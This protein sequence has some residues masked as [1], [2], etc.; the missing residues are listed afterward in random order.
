MTHRARF[1]IPLVTLMAVLCCSLRGSS[2]PAAQ[3]FQ[4]V[5]SSA[6]AAYMKNGTPGVEVVYVGE[7]GGHVV[8]QMLPFGT[9]GWSGSHVTIDASTVFEIGSVTKVFTATLASLGLAKAGISADSPVGPTLEGYAGVTPSSSFQHITF[10]QLATHTSGLPTNGI[11]GHASDE[12][13]ADLPPSPETVTW[14]NSFNAARSPGTCWDYSNSGFVTL[15]F[16]ASQILAPGKTSQYNALLA[17]DVTGPLSMYCTNAQLSKIP[18]PAAKGTIL[19]GD[20]TQRRVRTSAS[21][22]K[23]DGFDM[24]S[25][26]EAQLGLYTRTVP[27][28]PLTTAIAATQKIAVTDVPVCGKNGKRTMALGWDIGWLDPHDHARGRIYEKN[29]ATSLGGMSDA[30]AFSLDRKAGV[31]VLTNAFRQAG[32]D[33]EGAT[34]DEEPA[35][36]NPQALANQLLRTWVE[37]NP[38]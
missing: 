3:R 5:V 18:C 17:N 14:W 27:P 38:S 16:A 26:V 35:A 32:S 13:F 9:A 23:S 34:G 22:L 36:A 20:G 37:L 1:A 4:S 31:V 33:A 25:W 11:P 24:L 12:L 15:G 8:Y 7:T 30:V 28:E 21:D 10:T 6:V 29:G 2:A 19:L